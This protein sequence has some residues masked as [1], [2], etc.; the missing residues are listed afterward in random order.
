[1]TDST[2]RPEGEMLARK[3]P[4]ENCPWRKD[5]A[6]GEFDQDRYREL[7]R[8]GED[9]SLVLFT[10]H[11]STEIDPVV[12][13]GFLERGATHNLSVRL[14]LMANRLQPMDRSGGHD[15]YPNYRAMAVAQG[16][17]ADDPAMARCR[18]DQ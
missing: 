3:K 6:P 16:I 4:C 15:L 5:V 18:D 10:C 11:K 12:C 9:M 7:A 1:M 2:G 13:A 8:C 14:A 17:H